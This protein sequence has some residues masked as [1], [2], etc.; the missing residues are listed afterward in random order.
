MTMKFRTVK[1]AIEDILEA[2]ANECFT[3][4]SH[5]KQKKSSEEVLDL[6]RLVQ[7]YYSAGEFPKNAGRQTG[8][9]AHDVTYRLDLTVAKASEG[10]LAT[11][12]NPNAETFEL[13][14]ALA[15]FETA[16]AKADE[17]YDELFELVYQILMDARNRDMGQEV[18]DVSNR[19]ISQQQK[20][21]P[22]PRGQHVVLTGSMFLTLR[23]SEDIIGEEAVTLINPVQDVTIDQSGDDIE[24]TGVTVNV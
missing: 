11:L 1:T 4:I 9:T 16:A 14:E 17:S 15:T 22:L 8:P 2:A 24:Q 18:G 3:V 19:W 23:V 10:D 5:Q 13:A 21:Q 12:N 6:N 20:D 7:V